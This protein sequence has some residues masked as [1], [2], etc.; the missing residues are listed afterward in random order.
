MTQAPPIDVHALTKRYGNFWA[1][2]GV[3]LD[4]AA[5]EVF[6]LLGPNG[7]GKTTT[8][9]ILS[10]ARRRTGGTVRVLGQDPA[11]DVRGWR[12]R[13]GV[14]P[15]TTSAF[16]D[17]T[18]REV[19]AHFSAFYPAPLPVDQVLEMVG[20]TKER[21]KQATAMSGG[22]QRRLDI[23]VGIVGDPDLI[24]LD[25]PT[26]GLDPVARREA[27]ELIRGL[28]E[29]G[30]T[31]V[32]TTHYLEEAEALA[33]RVAVIVDG[34]VVASGR[35]AELGGRET[36]PVTVSFVRTGALRDLP[37]PPLPDDTVPDPDEQ[38]EHHVGLLTHTPT[39]VMRSVLA[40]AADAGVEELAELRVYQ[41][42]L[43]EIY[44]GLI[45]RSRDAAAS[46]A[47]GDGT[48]SSDPAGTTS[49]G[50]GDEVAR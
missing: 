2:R 41:P 30:K 9:E 33:N 34:R 26:T 22:Q 17:L 44:L 10:G 23:A 39:A 24:F 36:A 42:S 18:T 16:I 25:E 4:V 47:A 38:R 5:G 28:A 15:Q 29:R 32:L 12:A 19:V 27:W 1:V 13:I 21:K 11:D 48:G 20:L 46:E 14:V 50:S 49:D 35:T 43:E 37:L 3:D 6:A 45:R 40:W 8:V 7:A 31:T